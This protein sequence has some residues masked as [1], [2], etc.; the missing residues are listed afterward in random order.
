M[1]YCIL[2]KSK[3]LKP[4]FGSLS[5]VRRAVPGVAVDG[6][7]TLGLQVLQILKVERVKYYTKVAINYKLLFQQ[8]HHYNKRVENGK[9]FFIL[10]SHLKQNII[11]ASIVRTC[12]VIFL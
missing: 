3:M 4:M 7:T 10:F 11:S 2:I 9:P 1:K 6:D 12:S 5:G 8:M